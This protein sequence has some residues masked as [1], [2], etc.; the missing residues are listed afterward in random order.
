GRPAGTPRPVDADGKALT[1]AHRA[2]GDLDIILVSDV[3]VL[4][5]RFWVSTRNF[6]GR[7]VSTPVAGN[8]TFVVN[9][10]DAL[11]GDSALLDLRGRG[12]STR[13]C[14]VIDNL[15]RAAEHKF[16]AKEQELRDKLAD[17]EKKLRALTER[18]G[19]DGALLSAEDRRQIESYQRDLLAVRADLRAVQRSLRES[20]DGLRQ[21]LLF[22]NIA[23]VPILVAVL[24]LVLALVRRQRRRRP[25]LT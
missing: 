2:T 20:L 9:A 1:I 3:D 21:R 16:R 8:G 7:Q 18:G 25:V 6:F 13:P 12:M 24:A 4:I 23:A 5:D 22:V 11:A 17:T 10:L 14:V 15:E 19:G